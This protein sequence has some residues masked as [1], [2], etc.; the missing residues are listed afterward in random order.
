MC[1]IGR[2]NVYILQNKLKNAIAD[3]SSAIELEPEAAVIYHTRGK[4]YEQIGELDKAEE[5][6][7]KAED[8]GF[9]EDE[10]LDMFDDDEDWEDDDDWDDEDDEDNDNGDNIIEMDFGDDKDK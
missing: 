1:Y 10:F 4:L 5:D 3:F 7:L 2:A 6:F 9:D 8:L